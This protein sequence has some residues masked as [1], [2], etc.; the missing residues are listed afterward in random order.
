MIGCTNL[1]QTFQV[2]TPPP[3]SETDSGGPRLERAPGRSSRGNLG[4]DLRPWAAIIS[5]NRFL[6]H[7]DD[8]VTTN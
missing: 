3:R 4:H 8:Y 6:G 7:V 1:V 2:V 5:L